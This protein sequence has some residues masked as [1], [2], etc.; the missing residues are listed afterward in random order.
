MCSAVWSITCQTARSLRRPSPQHLR[1][2][3][4]HPRSWRLQPPR[5]VA[6]HPLLASTMAAALPAIS[7]PLHWIYLHQNPTSSPCPG[8][9][10]ITAPARSGCK[11]VLNGS[12]YDTTA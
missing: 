5:P 6:T 12:E 8:C 11:V 2:I 4:S 3:L 10:P 7:G 1:M 9:P